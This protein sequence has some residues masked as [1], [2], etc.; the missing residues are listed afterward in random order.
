MPAFTAAVALHRFGVGAKPG[1]LA[2]VRGDGA[3]FLREQL[4]RP[5]AALISAAVLPTSTEAARALVHAQQDK[6][7]ADQ[8]VTAS[9]AMGPMDLQ[10]ALASGN[11]G[12]IRR[13][14]YH[15]E[16]VT[17]LRHGAHSDAGFV[18]RLVLFWTNHFAV[19]VDKGPV[20]VLAGAMERE[21]IRPHVLGRFADL[22]KAVEQH[23]AMLLFLDNQQSTGPDSPAGR[24]SRRGLNENLAR[25]MLELHTVG[26]DAGYSQADVTSLANILTGWA[27]GPPGMD[28]SDS[29]AF[30]FFPQRH[31]PGVFTVM[32]RS[33]AQAGAAQ[34]EAVLQDLAAHPATARHLARKLAAHFIADEPP[35]AAVQRI[36]TAFRESGGDLAHVASAIVDCPEAWGPAPRKLTS[37]YEFVLGAARAQQDYLNDEAGLLRAFAALGQRP[38]APPS[39]KGFEDTTASWLAPHS[40]KERLEWAT[41]AAAK[42]PP[43]VNPAVLAD[44]LFGPLLSRQ[45]REEVARAAD[46]TQGMALLLMSPEFQRR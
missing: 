22:L 14:I 19:S 27:W 38:F 31:E 30:G 41:Q 8:Q 16:V 32:G 7:A 25:E 15:A 5:E 35:D 24:R 43:R 10:T 12:A 36:E 23:P 34:G 13:A 3:A 45:T 37:P 20:H 33:Y 42:S 18:E 21:A 6:R 39:P 28:R 4:S 40:F 26:V 46:A 29:G 9:A 2:A 17:R 44:D 11:P 1:E